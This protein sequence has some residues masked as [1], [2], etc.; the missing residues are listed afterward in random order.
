MT[1]P[2]VIIACEPERWVGVGS[3]TDLAVKTVSPIGFPTSV[4]TSQR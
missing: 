3:T 4:V 1:Q 2:T